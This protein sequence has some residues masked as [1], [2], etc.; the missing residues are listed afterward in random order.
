MI[1]GLWFANRE[2]KGNG[3]QGHEI[4][5]S[6]RGTPKPAYRVFTTTGSFV[7]FVLMF[8]QEKY[9]E[10]GQNSVWL[11]NHTDISPLVGSPSC[12]ETNTDCKIGHTTMA[13]HGHGSLQEETKF[14]AL[15]ISDKVCTYSFSFSV[16]H[17]SEN[18][19][20]F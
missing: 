5:S 20:W 10:H 11:Y 13:D 8:G 17:C 18:D 6:E 2:K 1:S 4:H 12:E 14:S 15:G 16:D 9:V 7:F 19:R 3:T